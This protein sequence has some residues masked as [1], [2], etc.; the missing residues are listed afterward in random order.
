MSPDNQQSER[1]APTIERAPKSPVWRRRP[2]SRSRK[3]SAAAFVAF[4]ALVATT[5]TSHA[6]Q[7]VVPSPTIAV[8]LCEDG[9]C[10][11]GFG[12]DHVLTDIGCKMRPVVRELSAEGL[13]VLAERIRDSH[14]RN[15]RGVYEAEVD[16][17]CLRHG[18]RRRLCS[19]PASVRRLSESADPQSLD[20]YRS[21]WL[22]TEQQAYR[23]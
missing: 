16:H 15:L 12:I 4:L 17:S 23:A 11:E 20:T 18:W 10:S 5:G 13:G 1:V 8:V 9:V 22:E 6:W 21:E 7:C 2:S 19:A 14:H 3:L